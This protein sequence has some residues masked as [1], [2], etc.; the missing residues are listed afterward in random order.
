MGLIS[1]VSSRTYRKTWPFILTEYYQTL[2][3]ESE[4]PGPNSPKPGSTNQPRKSLDDQH[5]LL[6]PPPLPHEQLPVLF[7]PSSSA[8]LSGTTPKPE[9]AEVSLDELKGAGLSATEAK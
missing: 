1:R 9:S 4:K 6:K 3:S 2:T 8:Q 5:E 7:D